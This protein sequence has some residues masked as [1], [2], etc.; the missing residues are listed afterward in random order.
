MLFPHIPLPACVLVVLAFVLWMLLTNSYRKVERYIIGF[1]GVIGISFIVEL[2]LVRASWSEAAIGW[3]V[4]SMPAGSIPVVMSVLGA[5]VMPHNLFLHSEIIQ[6]RQWNLEN[7][8][9]ISRQLRF[10][11]LDTLV[12]MLVG[13]GINSAMIL[14]AAATFF[15]HQQPID[16]LRQAQQMLA[17]LLGDSASAIFAIALL[18]AG[19]AS[20][21]T[22]GM[23]GGSIY[24]GIFSEP[25]DIKDRHTRDGVCITLLGATAIILAMTFF[26]AN[27]F[28]GLVL[29]Q[30]VLSVQLPWTIFMQVRL[31]SSEAVMGVHANGR[32][33]RTLLWVIGLIVA[34]LNMLLLI[35]M[36]HA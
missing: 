8:V 10:E 6:S 35:S 29:S 32:L 28:M 4:P 23:A 16:D 12:S 11:F 5:V 24:A 21:I 27:L 1:V 34:G 19:L 14:V 17:P 13:W 22:A 15:M 9:V 20:S 31:T 7:E 26:G 2:I 18:C 25:Y 3:V 33:D 36:L 30:V